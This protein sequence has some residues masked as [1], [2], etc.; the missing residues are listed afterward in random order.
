MV[1]RKI[2]LETISTELPRKC[3]IATFNS[4]F[5]KGI[6][7]DERVIIY[8][9]N[10]I[11]KGPTR[12]S[13]YDK[14]VIRQINQ[15]D[16]SSWE[17]A[18]NKIVRDSMRIKAD[19]RS[20]KKYDADLGVV[21][22]FE[23]G[24]YEDGQGK[25]HLIPL[26]KKLKENNIVNIIIP[27]SVLEH[28]EREDK[29]KGAQYERIM[30][31]ALECT[32]QVIC[33]TPSAVDILENRYGAPRELLKHVDHGINK[34]EIPYTRDAL[35]KG[36]NIEGR[37]TYSSGGF[38]SE[39]KD[40][41]VVLKALSKLKQD[42][43]YFCFGIDHPDVA[44]KARAFRRYCIQ[45]SKELGQNPV[46]IGRGERDKLGLDELKKYNLRNNKVVFFDKF[47]NDDDSLKSKI[48]SDLCI[49]ANKGESQISSGELARA[50]EAWRI[51]IATSSPC[52]RD[53]EKESGVFTVE[54]GSVD[55]LYS[56]I[57]FIFSKSEEERRGLEL[58]NAV[59]GS[60][61]YFEDKSKD[62]INILDT[63]IHFN[64]LYV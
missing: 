15:Y 50:L 2:A 43:L 24:I 38:F 57:N 64:R 4:N 49:I 30:M 3:G 31:E 58:A 22:Q 39:G 36:L 25:D 27:H 62:I 12:Y 28:P 51:A 10:A 52:S 23:Y 16:P 26:L 6:G 21:V 59:K 19:Y 37:S 40:I 53:M 18:G 5:L 41:P 13:T 29:D 61:M 11:V 44:E 9:R 48:M 42:Y 60:L 45:L 47:L 35:K 33:L 63:L 54:H 34:L 20:W 17:E 14:D 7:N 32:N 56:C 8:K 1:S 46:L 55:S